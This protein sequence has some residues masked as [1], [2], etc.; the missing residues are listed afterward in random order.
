M[1]IVNKKMIEMIPG[2]KPFNFTDLIEKAQ[3]KGYKIRVYPISEDS[4]ID[5][6]Q[7]EEYR[8]AIDKLETR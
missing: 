1:Y 2:N 6:G 4:W 7:W 8:K 5:I 3:T